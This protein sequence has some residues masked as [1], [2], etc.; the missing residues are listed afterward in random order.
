[1]SRLI[2]E[3]ESDL[4]ARDLSYLVL[5]SLQA[6][7]KDLKV[8]DENTLC[9]QFHVFLKVIQNTKPKIGIIIEY[10]YQISKAIERAEEEERKINASHQLK[11]EHIKLVIIKTIDEIFQQEEEDNNALLQY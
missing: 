7:V 4:G 6:T 1:M 9:D 10:M 11:C 5:K 2:L 3:V 8:S